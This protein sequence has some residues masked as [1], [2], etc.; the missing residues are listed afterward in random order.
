M[1]TEIRAA[2]AE[3]LRTATEIADRLNK[4][5]IRTP[6]GKKLSAHSIGRFKEWNQLRDECGVTLRSR[7]SEPKGPSE[8]YAVIDAV[9]KVG[10]PLSLTER[11]ELA[12]LILAGGVVKPPAQA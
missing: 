11:V 9:L 5:G 7:A 6:E 2:F 8:T 12:A 3:G 1:K 10:N 4:I